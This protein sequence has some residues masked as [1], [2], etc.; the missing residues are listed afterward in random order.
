MPPKAAYAAN[1]RSSCGSIARSWS[2]L[3][4]NVCVAPDAVDCPM[5]AKAGPDGFAAG[6]AS[7]SNA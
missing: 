2:I 4:W 5:R 7:S 6:D 3:P 1:V